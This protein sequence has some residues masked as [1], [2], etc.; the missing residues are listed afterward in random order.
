[1]EIVKKPDPILSK[2]T[3]DI[4]KI[5]DSVKDVIVRLWKTHKENACLG[6]AAPQIGISLNVTVIGFEPNTQD[7]KKTD[8]YKDMR[9]IPRTVLI[10]PKII[11][12]SKE[13]FIEKEACLSVEKE[14]ADIPRYKVVQIEYLDE[15]G[16]KQKMKAK[17]FVAR[18]VQ[19]EIDHLQGKTIADY[20]Q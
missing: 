17:G 4:V 12:H 19:H 20:R 3:K 5:D 10:T 9:P 1:M 8:R 18:V 16:R 7:E 14:E 13:K 6:V 15:A 2:K 11:S